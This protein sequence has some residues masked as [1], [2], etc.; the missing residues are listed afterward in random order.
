MTVSCALIIA[1]D[2]L[3]TFIYSRQIYHEEILVMLNILSDLNET[4]WKLVMS[5]CD[6]C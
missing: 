2:V 1:A 3:I 6:A 4:S 5:F